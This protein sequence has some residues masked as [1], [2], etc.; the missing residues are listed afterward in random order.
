[1]GYGLAEPTRPNQNQLKI[2]PWEPDQMTTISGVLLLP[3]ADREQITVR[4]RG[5]TLDNTSWP[6]TIPCPCSCSLTAR[7]VSPYTG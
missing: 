6:T 5:N 1:M 7:A 3:F 2:L 4:A